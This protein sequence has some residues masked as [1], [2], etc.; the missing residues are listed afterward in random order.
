M[1]AP[2]DDD[3]ARRLYF[4]VAEGRSAAEVRAAIDACAC[5]DKF[6]PSSIAAD[7]ARCLAIN[8]FEPNE[9]NDGRVE[10][11]CA[12]P[13]TACGAATSSDCCSR[14][15]PTRLLSTPTAATTPWP[16]AWLADRRRA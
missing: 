7:R 14:Q 5:A 4:A 3:T 1:A 11:P 15:A 10:T 13:P 2:D 8:R 12:G 6:T 9:R 16:C